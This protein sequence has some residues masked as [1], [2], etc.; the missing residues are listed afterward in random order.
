MYCHGFPFPL[1]PKLAGHVRMVGKN[2]AVKDICK[3][4]QGYHT[5]F[6]FF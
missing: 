6:L 2:L 1:G 5:L 3:V 4:G